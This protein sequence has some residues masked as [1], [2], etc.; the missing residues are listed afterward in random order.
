MT[1]NS[2]RCPVCDSTCIECREQIDC[3]CASSMF[4]VFPIQSTRKNSI[5]SVNFFHRAHQ[6]CHVTLHTCTQVVEFFWMDSFSVWVYSRFEKISYWY[7]IFREGPVEGQWIESEQAEFEVR[8]TLREPVMQSCGST[9][10]QTS[11]VASNQKCESPKLRCHF[12]YQLSVSILLGEC[13][14]KLPECSG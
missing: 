10:F 13:T 1:S 7:F 12:V 5:V 11:V 14:W 9:R 2:W 3:S 8:S 4:C 6:F